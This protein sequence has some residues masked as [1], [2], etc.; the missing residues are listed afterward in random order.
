[1]K[2][3]RTILLA[4]TVVAVLFTAVACEKDKE[5]YDA[6]T[7][8]DVVG[9]GYVF[10]YDS[11]D[12]ILYPVR[13]ATIEI[14]AILEGSEGVDWI[15]PPRQREYF[16]T[17]TNGKYQIRFIKRTKRLDAVRYELYSRRE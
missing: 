3:I 1:M 11:A 5:D 16:Y 13:S 8:Y 4:T 9:E 15:G 7:Y 10:M 17:D 14:T 2:N 12:N 6:I